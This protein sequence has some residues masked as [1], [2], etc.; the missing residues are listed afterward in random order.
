[1]SILQFYKNKKVFITGHT[2]FKG[3]WLSYLLLNVGAEVTGFSLCPPTKPLLFEELIL[4]KD[5]QL[6]IGDIIDLELLTKV[7]HEVQPEI[8]LH[9]AAQPIVRESYKN[10]VMTY[11]TNVIVRRHIVG[12]AN[13]TL[14]SVETPVRLCHIGTYRRLSAG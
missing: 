6:L 14:I 1:M 8:V 10:P 7:F 5:M 12:G 4:E 13:R 2:G 9:L 11:Q 3:S